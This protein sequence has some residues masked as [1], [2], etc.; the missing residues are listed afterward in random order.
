[1][2]PDKENGCLSSFNE[3]Q[4]SRG[5]PSLSRRWV[6]TNFY[7][8]EGDNP[9]LSKSLRRIAAA[10]SGRRPSASGCGAARTPEAFLNLG[11]EKEQI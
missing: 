4:L 2:F 8:V 6:I 10:L 5:V 7:A 3:I 9:R 11:Y 1:M